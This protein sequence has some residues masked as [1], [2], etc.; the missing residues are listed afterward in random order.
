[1]EKRNRN[2]DP[3]TSDQKSEMS[4]SEIKLWNEKGTTE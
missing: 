2:F 1:M 3:L 4:E